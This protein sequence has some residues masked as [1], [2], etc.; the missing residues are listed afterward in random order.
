LAGRMSS[1]LIWVGFWLLLMGF[2]W[3]KG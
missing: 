2:G 1:M 3:G